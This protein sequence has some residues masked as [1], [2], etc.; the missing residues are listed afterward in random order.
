V[1]AV[2]ALVLA[3][4]ENRISCSDNC[5][6]FLQGMQPGFAQFRNSFGLLQPE[7]GLGGSHK[8]ITEIR[9]S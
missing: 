4:A 1:T 3:K 5:G 7:R 9:Q 8:S 6:D 2:T